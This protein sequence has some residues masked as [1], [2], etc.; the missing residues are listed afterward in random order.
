LLELCI[1]PT[2]IVI[3]RGQK[4]VTRHPCCY[5][6]N[7]DIENPDHLSRLLAERKPGEDTRLLALSPKA[8]TY[9]SALL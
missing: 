5:G 2:T 9:Y 3:Y 4:L 8:E 1:E 6:H 7:Q